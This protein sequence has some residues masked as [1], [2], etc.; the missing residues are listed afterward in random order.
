MTLQK[1]SNKIS[2]EYDIPEDLNAEKGLLSCVLLGAFSEAEEL[3]VSSEWFSDMRHQQIWV[4]CESIIKDGGQIDQVTV[5]RQS[6]KNALY[7]DDLIEHSP[8]AS[9]LSYYSK[10]AYAAYIRRK[11]FLKHYAAIEE[12]K[13]EQDP[14][15]LLQRLQDDLWQTTRGMTAEKDQRAAQKGFIEVLESAVDGGVPDLSIKSGIYGLDQKLGGFLPG[16]VYIISGRPGGGKSA[17][18]MYL[19]I[20]AAKQGKRVALWSLEM[21][22]NSIAERA[23]AILSGEDVRHYLKT[24]HGDK[25]KIA[26]ATKEFFELPIHI[27][28]TPA[29]TVDQLRSQARRFVQ[30]KGVDMLIIDYL[31]LLRSGGRYENRVNEVG[32]MTRT[33]KII[34]LECGVPVLLLAQMNREFDKRESSIPRLSD[35][36]DSGTAEQ[37]ADSVGFLVPNT[38]E[39]EPDDGIVNF[40]IRKNR[41]GIQEAKVSLEYTRWNSRFTGVEGPPVL[42][43]KLPK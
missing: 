34:A 16:A 7:I 41:N 32:A 9:N 24:G 35:L 22:Y 29:I 15:K 31:T 3:G 26:R 27:E 1:Q 12:S 11:V 37:D 5:S 28:D 39:D 4:A 14:E 33:I 42:E 40:Y 21:L 23:V 30:D 6:V 10:Q 18:S 43:N 19:A 8:S 38:K 17:F 36:R 25:G 13:I 2:I 20:Q